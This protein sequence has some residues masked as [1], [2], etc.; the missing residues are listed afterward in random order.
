MT[1][2]SEVKEFL[3]R[4]V[5]LVSWLVNIYHGKELIAYWGHWKGDLLVNKW[6]CTDQIR[7]GLKN[8][9]FEVFCTKG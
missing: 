7:L 5:R 2:D 6:E 3:M 9:A 8:Y 1:G 4:M